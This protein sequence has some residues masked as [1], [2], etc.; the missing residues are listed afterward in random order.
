[1]C[2][3]AWPATIPSL[4]RPRTSRHP[5][6]PEARYIVRQTGVSATAS[7]RIAD[8]PARNRFN[9]ILAGCDPNAHQTCTGLCWHSQV[10]GFAALAMHIDTIDLLYIAFPRNDR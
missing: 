2:S 8:R 7:R 1:M 3:P 4:E 5:M 9:H 10:A 6:P